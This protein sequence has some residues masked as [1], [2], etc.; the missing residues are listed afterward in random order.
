MARELQY[1]WRPVTGR[2]WSDHRF[3][4][5]SDRGRMLWLYFLTAPA[6]PI[7]GVIISGPARVAE[8]LTWSGEGVLEGFR[9]IQRSGLQARWEGRVIWLVNSLRH[10]PVNGPNA[11]HGWRPFW[12][13][14]PNVPLKAD[15]WQS[16]R[17]ACQRWPKVFAEALPKPVGE[18]VGYPVLEDGH[19]G[20][21]RNTN[22]ITN[23][24]TNTYEKGDSAP[25]AQGGFELLK[26][27][28]DAYAGDVGKRRARKPRAKSGATETERAIALR[29]LERLGEHN[30]VRYTGTD[31]HVA[32]VAELLRRGIDEAELRAIVAHCSNQWADKP[33]AIEWLRPETLFGPKTHTRYLDPARSRYA[34]DIAAF[35]AKQSAPLTLSIVPEA[36]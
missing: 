13:D 26:S 31:E 2:L 1:Y 10:Q 30:G 12:K 6:L 28:V 25:A 20:D 4:S 16:L 5:M 23:T 27:K 36:G 9:E 34:A 14:I 21:P 29:L 24:N 15:L 19:P 8:D 11:I 35:R 22:T 3:L 32:L 33:E 7:P 18:P 17:I